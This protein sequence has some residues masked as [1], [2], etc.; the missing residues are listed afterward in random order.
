[1]GTNIMLSREQHRALCIL[2][3]N[4]AKESDLI[5]SCD[6][7][8][9]MFETGFVGFSSVPLNNNNLPRETGWAWNQSSAKAVVPVNGSNV[10]TF[11]KLNVRKR[12]SCTIPPSY[13]L[14]VYT[15]ESSE[16]GERYFLWCEKGLS[17]CRSFTIGKPIPTS[18]IPPP[19]SLTQHMNMNNP[20]DCVSL[21]LEDLKFLMPFMTQTT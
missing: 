10:A 13:K 9:G 14:W 16:K 19:H 8:S 3:D 20:I 21:H 7:F 12:R 17:N 1:M 15:V 18:K 5:L 11:Y 6:V 2:Q 4:L